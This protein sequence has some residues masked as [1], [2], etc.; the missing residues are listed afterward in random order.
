MKYILENHRVAEAASFC[1][2]NYIISIRWATYS[3]EKVAAKL[4]N[5]QNYS[6]SAKP[7]NFQNFSGTIGKVS[8]YFELFQDYYFEIRLARRWEVPTTK[9][10]LFCM[11]KAAEKR[12]KKL[13]MAA[14]KGVHYDEI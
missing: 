13:E 11:V 7:G 10:Q 2:S 14:M 8:N 3:F 6:G 9:Y 5:F 12:A 1:D 4:G